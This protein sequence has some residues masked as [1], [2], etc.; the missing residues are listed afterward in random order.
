[1]LLVPSLHD[2]DQEGGSTKGEYF[3]QDLF[4]ARKIFS[5]NPD[6]HLDVGSRIDGFVAH[7]ASFRELEV[8]DVRPISSEIPGIEFVEADLSDANSMS[9][10]HLSDGYCDS[11]SCLHALEHF[12]LGRYGDPLDASGFKKGL[13]N[14]AKLLKPAGVLYLSTPVGKERVEFNAN[15]VFHPD[16]IIQEARLN[17]LTLAACSVLYPGAESII[18]L[19][20]A[21]SIKA[22]G[23]QEYCLA[24]FELQKS[25]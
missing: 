12:G 8:V 6:K 11:V 4:V 13:K 22:L 14:L 17:G 23:D 18:T 15:W 3:L 9:A 19:S 10:F 7:V 20:D 2:R 5:A 21:E 25:R 1:M 24:I 16:T